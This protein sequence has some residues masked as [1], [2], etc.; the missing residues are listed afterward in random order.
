[1]TTWEQGLRRRVLSGFRNS[2]DFGSVVG[3]YYA[4]LHEC[5]F[6]RWFVDA[7][8]QRD[9]DEL[10]I[11][12]AFAFAQILA[13]VVRGRI[14]L[15]QFDIGVRPG[16]DSNVAYNHD[17]LQELCGFVDNDTGAPLELDVSFEGG[18]RDQDGSVVLRSDL[19][20]SNEPCATGCCPRTW[21]VAAA[22]TWFPLEVGDTTAARSLGHIRLERGLVRWPY[23]STA[24]TF[25]Y[26][27]QLYD[28]GTRVALSGIDATPRCRF[29]HLARKSER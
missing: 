20:L 22:G 29:G 15:Q 8:V 18:L 2:D 9:R 1:M 11:E 5:R 21:T 6:D 16:R 26:V 4:R 3:E 10:T 17:A 28:P 23:D 24:V 7:I 12:D 27:P 14:V 25:F 19:V 13:E